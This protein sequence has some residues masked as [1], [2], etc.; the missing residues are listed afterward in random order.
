MTFSTF[1]LCPLWVCPLHLASARSLQ[2]NLSE[3]R[4]GDENSQEQSRKCLD[5]LSTISL[6]SS[7]NFLEPP[8]VSPAPNALWKVR[9]I[10]P[11]Q[12]EDPFPQA[13][14]LPSNPLPPSSPHPPGSF[15]NAPGR[16]RPG[17]CGGRVP[18]CKAGEGESL[19]RGTWGQ[20]HI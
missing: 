10:P 12:L 16:G 13:T 18:G 5:N 17:W 14:V 4:H 9:P 11:L 7:Q 2:D 8:D 19:P 3:F 20:T 6:G 1:A 15:C